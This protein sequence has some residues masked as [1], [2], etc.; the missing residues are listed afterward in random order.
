MQSWFRVSSGHIHPI[1]TSVVV[2]PDD[3]VSAA[4]CPCLLLLYR[5]F[6]QMRGPDVLLNLLKQPSP[7]RPPSMTN[8]HSPR[9]DPELPPGST[10]MTITP[11]LV[12]NTSSS[13]PP[14]SSSMLPTTVPTMSTAASVPGSSDAVMDLIAQEIEL[15]ALLQEWS[16]LMVWKCDLILRQGEMECKG[17]MVVKD[18][19]EATRWWDHDMF[20]K[21]IEII[22]TSRPVSCEVI[23]TLFWII[24]GNEPQPVDKRKLGKRALQ[25]DNFLATVSFSRVSIVRSLFTIISIFSA[26][27]YSSCLSLIG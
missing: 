7:V 13:T 1:R 15:Y 6:F 8:I 23:A 5:A 18:K 11:S 22:S 24:P 12:A 20:M 10:F 9:D 3:E 14:S 4:T 26:P 21:S 25:L 17:E 27:L 19:V 2:N 16:T